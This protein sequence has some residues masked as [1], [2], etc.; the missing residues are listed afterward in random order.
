M[1]AVRRGC[2]ARRRAQDRAVRV[3]VDPRRDLR[4]RA[5]RDRLAA[6]HDRQQV[7]QRR[8]ALEIVVRDDQLGVRPAGEESGDVARDGRVVLDVRPRG[9]PQG[10][11]EQRQARGLGT[12]EASALRR[13]ADRDQDRRPAGFQA[14]ARFGGILIQS[15]PVE[16]IDAGLDEIERSLGER[17]GG[18]VRQR[19]RP[20]GHT[21][22]ERPVRELQ[23]SKKLPRRARGRDR[24]RDQGRSAGAGC[25][26]GSQQA[27][28][29]ARDPG[30]AAVT[31]NATVTA[32]ARRPAAGAASTE[33]AAT[34][35]SARRAGRSRA[36]G[37]S[38]CSGR[39]GGVGFRVR[40]GVRDGSLRREVRSL[41]VRAPTS[42]QPRAHHEPGDHS[43]TPSR[44][45]NRPSNSRGEAINDH[46]DLSWAAVGRPAEYASSAGPSKFRAY[47]SGPLAHTAASG[48]RRQSA[49]RNS[50]RRVGAAVEHVIL[51]RR[52][53]GLVDRIVL[54]SAQHHRPTRDREPRTSRAAARFDCTFSSTGENKRIGPPRQATGLGSASINDHESPN[55]PDCP[56]VRRPTGRLSYPHRLRRGWR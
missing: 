36:A 56:P 17:Q 41:A 45:T 39:S 38:A 26:R 15:L 20:I 52:R 12:F 46:R 9:D 5:G 14:R 3:V 33:R 32:A 6:R 35:S 18:A 22:D 4:D 2:R 29:R 21:D 51:K 27:A 40:A 44:S 10:V 25:A 42:E 34:A 49:A 50:R 55:S 47:N 37:R 13:R 7:G 54:A 31:R 53:P 8:R 28:A 11:P 23:H 43:E 24:D 1:T 30:S 19:R 16:E 48:F